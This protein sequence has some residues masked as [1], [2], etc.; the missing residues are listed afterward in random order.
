MDVLSFIRLSFNRRYVLRWIVAGLVLFIPVID[1]FSLGYLWR[2]ATLAMVGGMGLPTWERKK[3]LWKEGARLVGIVILYE[4]L[5]SFLFSLGF[6]VSSPGNT[7]LNVAGGALQVFSAVAFIGCSFLLPFAFCSFAERSHFPDAFELEHIW[8]LAKKVL[9]PYGVGYAAVG[10]C[11]YGASRLRAFP[12]IGVLLVSVVAFY[13]FLVSS[14]YFTD[15]YHRALFSEVG[16]RT[17]RQ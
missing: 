9:L 5:P 12:Y 11:L 1:F 10:V 16:Q 6:L 4:A 13:V 14:Y 15:L 3:E 8:M 17:R 7:I 2:T